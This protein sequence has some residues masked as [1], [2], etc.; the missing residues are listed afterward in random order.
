MIFDSGRALAGMDRP[1]FHW[2]PGPRPTMAL[3]RTARCGELDENTVAAQ[4][5][6]EGLLAHAAALR[7]SGH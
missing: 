2:T 6:D 5:D 1:P 4:G 7:L 3:T